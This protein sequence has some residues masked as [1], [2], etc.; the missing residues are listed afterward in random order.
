M[1]N[2]NIIIFLS[3]TLLIALSFILFIVIKD[4]NAEQLL[5]ENPLV[6]EDKVFESSL[7]QA[8]DKNTEENIYNGDLVP[9]VGIVIASNKIFLVSPTLPEQNVV[10]YSGEKFEINATLYIEEGTIKSFADLK[11][12]PNLT[13]LKIY[14]QKNA[15]YNTLGSLPNINN[16]SLYANNIND[17]TFIESLP[18]ISY[19]SLSY[20]KI[21][22]LSPLKNLTKLKTLTINNNNIKNISE[23]ETLTTLTSLQLNNNE[24]SDISEIANLTYLKYLSLQNNNITDVSPLENLKNL[25]NLFIKTNPIAN[26]ESLNTLTIIPQ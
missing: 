22:N 25:E 23:L 21:E 8:L 26:I 11:H 15:D 3:T 24:I 17:L 13:N 9:Y 20:N 6:F 16:L 2:R 1:K 18:N 7:K 10:L 12:F 14:F 5:R 4:S 19:L